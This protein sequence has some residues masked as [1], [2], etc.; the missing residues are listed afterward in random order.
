MSFI[1]KMSLKDVREASIIKVEKRGD[2][3]IHYTETQCCYIEIKGN[4]DLVILVSPCP[5]K[6]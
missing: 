4:E 1:Q 6:L 5:Y 3:T 2:L